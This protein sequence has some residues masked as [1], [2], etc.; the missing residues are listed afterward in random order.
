MLKYTFEGNIKVYFGSRDS[1]IFKYIYV[2]NS[3]LISVIYLL[4]I[5][6]NGYSSRKFIILIRKIY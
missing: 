2:L 3:T 4:H 6:I 5:K 1:F